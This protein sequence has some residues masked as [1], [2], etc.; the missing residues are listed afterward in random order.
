MVDHQ[1]ADGDEE[2]RFEAELNALIREA[3]EEGVDVTGG[4]VVRDGH[5]AVQYDVVVTTV[6]QP[7]D[8]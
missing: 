7:A 1:L 2:R 3:R 5:D 4:W 8:D 6:R